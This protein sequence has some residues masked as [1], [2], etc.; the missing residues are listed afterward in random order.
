MFIVK[1]SNTS[2]KI[3]FVNS[4]VTKSLRFSQDM[5]I[6]ECVYFIREKTQEGGPDHG[7]FQPAVP[8]KAHGRWL[9]EDRTLMYYDI[10]SGVCTAFT[11]EVFPYS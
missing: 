6:A 4:G 3:F 5:S 11:D 7:L 8:G 9:S 1:L 10:F 2:Q